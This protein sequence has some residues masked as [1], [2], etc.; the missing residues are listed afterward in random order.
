MEKM[1]KRGLERTKREETESGGRRRGEG[2][3]RRGGES[4]G[5]S[6]RLSRPPEFEAKGTLSL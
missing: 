5:G 2:W 4:I 3:V 6:E 1:T